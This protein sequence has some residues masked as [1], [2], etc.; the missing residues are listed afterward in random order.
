MSVTS[1]NFKATHKGKNRL[2]FS[3]QLFLKGNKL[4]LSEE[5][6]DANSRNQKNITNVFHI[7]K[8][9]NDFI[10]VF[11]TYFPSLFQYKRKYFN[12]IMKF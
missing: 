2:N 11:K 9:Q 4:T 6:N 10:F 12:F 8:A 3:P 1:I 7:D 5:K